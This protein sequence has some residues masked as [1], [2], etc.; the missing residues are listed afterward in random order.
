MNEKQSWHD[1]YWDFRDPLWV[2]LPKL[3]PGC[4]LETISVNFS[5]SELPLGS[6]GGPKNAKKLINN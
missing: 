5:A 4:Y 2:L 6:L 1:Y 3:D